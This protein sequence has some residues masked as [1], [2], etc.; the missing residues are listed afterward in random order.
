MAKAKPIK[1][2]E[3]AQP[4]L[5]APE[6]LPAQEVLLEAAKRYAHTG[7]TACRDEEL[8]EQV[9]KFYLTTGSLRLTARQFH[10]SPNTVSA[11]LTVFSANGKLDALKQRLS[12]KL[13][14]MVELG[15]DLMIEKLQDGSVQ[16]NVLP[17]VIGVGVEKKAL[18]DGEATSR[19]ESAPAA[20]AQLEDLARYLRSQGIT[21]PAID[22]ASTVHPAEPQ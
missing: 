12:T 5:F 17:I 3:A 18:I 19:T 22:V 14:T 4:A 2:A 7:K 10:V 9:L 20:P 1:P 21:T 11:M 8:A 6:Q 15:T 16:A 13:G